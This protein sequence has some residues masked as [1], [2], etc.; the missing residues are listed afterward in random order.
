M[1]TIR[2]SRHYFNDDD[3]GDDRTPCRVCHS[4]VFLAIVC[5]FHGVDGMKKGGNQKVTRA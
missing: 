3:E 1:I 2:V 4:M 5:C